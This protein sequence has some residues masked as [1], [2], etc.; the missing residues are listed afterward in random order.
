MGEPGLECRTSSP[1]LADDL[2]RELSSCGREV[3][4]PAGATIFGYGEVGGAMYVVER[5]EVLL[6]FLEGKFAKR[7]GPGSFF[8]E[9]ALLGERRPRTATATAL[10]D[11]TLREL[12]HTVFDELLRISPRVLALLLR[13]TCR[14]LVESQERLLADV[15][16]RNVELELSLD[17]LR[18]MKHELDVAELQA[19]T[20]QLTGLY[21]RHCLKAQIPS[22]EAGARDPTVGIAVLLL[23]LDGFKTVNDT[24]GHQVG[25]AVLREV[26]RL[27]RVWIR[28]SDL[29]FRMG[30]DEFLVVMRGIGR[31]GALSR[32]E[33]MRSALEALARGFPSMPSVSIGIATFQGGDTWETVLERADQ[34]LYRAKSA[35]GNRVVQEVGPASP[36]LRIRPLGQG[37]RCRLPPEE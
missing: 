37:E 28:Q 4:F 18:R 23:D 14:Y 25:D 1:V 34:N 36:P 33:Q 11:S 31:E 6:E 29:P 16:R 24:C 17:Y 5:G 9:L 19:M 30:G 3:R 12:D 8:G 27:L 32:A 2:M 7:L 15:Q 20:D 10:A 35:G 22:I 21:N 26:G 13:H